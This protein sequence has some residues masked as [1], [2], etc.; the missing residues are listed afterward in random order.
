MSQE[1]KRWTHVSLEKGVAD[2]IKPMVETHTLGFTSIAEFIVEA[3]REKLEHYIE[4]GVHPWSVSKRPHKEL[5]RPIGA[6]L[7][8][9]LVGAVGALVLASGGGVQGMLVRPY[10]YGPDVISFYEANW[11]LVDL[12][13]Y[14]T[15]FS[16][17]AYATVGRRFAHR[18]IAVGV[19][20]FLAI[21]MAGLEARYGFAI[22]DLGGVAASFL[23][24]VL[25][26][27]MYHAFR[28]LNIDRFGSASLTLLIAYLGLFVMMPSVFA[29]LSVFFPLAGVLV[30]VL[31]VVGIYHIATHMFRRPALAGLPESAGLGAARE[32]EGPLRAYLSE[33][34]TGAR[35]EIKALSAELAYVYDLI[36]KHADTPQGRFLIAQKLKTLVPQE[37]DLDR[38]LAAIKDY[39]S[40]IESADKT[41]LKS[42]AGG[43][44]GLS[45]PGKKRMVRAMQSA[46]A[47]IDAE[48]QVRRF[49]ERAQAYKTALSTQVDAA[50]KVLARGEVKAAK[51]ALAESIAV[52]GRAEKTLA[53][54]LAFEDL[55]GRIVR[56]QAG[57][58]R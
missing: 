15:I 14:V 20:V 21:A 22:R 57:D 29:W 32:Q 48:E 55:L 1:R 8:V 38:A 36:D 44:K 56:E 25:A 11:F 17:I 23:T 35:K 43:A 13:V 42:F 47:K 3:A 54:M 28:Q 26:V 6:A 4:I 33:V 24:V 53:D 18:G 50:G 27:S 46:L 41:V 2:W 19:G 34:T 45:E 31:F 39:V 5:G 7:I 30:T 9:L 51:K 58:A 12:L 10:P 52:A 37:L 49:D 16:S 40:K